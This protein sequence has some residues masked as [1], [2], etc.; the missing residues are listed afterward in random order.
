VS[1]RFGRHHPPKQS[2]VLVATFLVAMTVSGVVASYGS[3]SPPKAKLGY[4][5]VSAGGA[6]SPYGG[7]G[8]F[9][10]LTGSG[11]NASV[12]G[13]A[14]TPDGGGYWL[15]ASDGRVSAFGDARL[16]GSLVGRRLEKPVVAIATTPDGAGYWLAAASGAV[17][18]FGDAGRYGSG[19]TKDL[20][21]PV[22]GMAVVPGGGGYWLA[23][24]NGD[25]IAFG[26]VPVT[27]PET[28]AHPTSPVVGIAATPDGKGYW[29]VTSNGQVL[30]FGD[31]RHYQPTMRPRFGAPVVG[32]APAP[33]GKGYWLATRDGGVFSFGSA[34]YMGSEPGQPVVAGHRLRAA[35]AWV[36]GIAANWQFGRAQ[37]GRQHGTTTPTTVGTSTTTS[38]PSS[39]SGISPVGTLAGVSAPAGSGAASLSVDPQHVGD[40]MLFGGED[41]N[42][43]PP[44]ISS[45]SGGGVSSWTLLARDTDT[46]NT[47]DDLEIWEGV[48]TA[49]GPSEITIT[50]DG[51]SDGDDL[52]AQEF[53]A[54]NA[55]TWS[56]DKSGEV[57]GT[58]AQDFNYPSLSPASSAELY[59][60]I[61]TA[62]NNTQLL[63]NGT[64]GVTYVQTGLECV[65]LVAY[66][67]STSA[68]LAPQVANASGS[69]NWETALAVLV[70][71]TH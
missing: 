9:G 11:S 39:G 63:G 68:S 30:T 2:I 62:I 34:E 18:A 71:A 25:V 70:R 46:P 12:V 27:P 59:F 10:S 37:R 22:V 14:S 7:A 50:P 52:M 49:V 35:S 64:A 29:L 13:L 5:I 21:S 67:T 8:R 33:D 44:V 40:L 69:G 23:T 24:Q 32:I 3:A 66:D 54:G 65:S 61:G 45:V 60:G 48:V 15:V 31:A 47:G 17:F 26:H 56:F 1:S 28:S 4:W 16:F 58:S 57:T 55:V 53:T 20:K 51:F 41:S 36:S 6:V 38:V 42:S 43:V 19:A